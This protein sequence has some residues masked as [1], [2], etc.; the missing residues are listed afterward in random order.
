MLWDFSRRN[1]TRMPVSCLVQFGEHLRQGAYHS[2]ALSRLR[3]TISCPAMVQCCSHPVPGCP[4]PPPVPPSHHLP[5]ARVHW[6]LHPFPYQEVWQGKESWDLPSASQLKSFQGLLTW[7]RMLLLL[8]LSSYSWQNVPCP[9]MDRNPLPTE[10]GPAYHSG[11]VAFNDFDLCLGYWQVLPVQSKKSSSF[12]HPH[13][14]FHFKNNAFQ[15]QLGQQ[16]LL[17][18]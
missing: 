3:C 14:S 7:M 5:P 6:L 8:P 17:E 2:L 15:C 12:H 16:L 18:D 13:R 1:W 4:P 10:E 9:S 11:S